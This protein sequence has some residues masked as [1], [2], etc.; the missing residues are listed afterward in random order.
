MIQG[1][2]KAVWGKRMPQEIDWEL[3]N[4]SNDRSETTNLAD[5]YPD[6]VKRMAE[7]WERY[8]ERTGVAWEE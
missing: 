4:L 1:D 3:Y 5:R 8:A 6:R 7:D 2:W